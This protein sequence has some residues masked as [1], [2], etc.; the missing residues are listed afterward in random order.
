VSEL[1]AQAAA[2]LAERAAAGGPALREA[3]LAVSRAAQWEWLPYMGDR[4][5]TITVK[6]RFIASRTAEIPVRIYTPAGEGPFPALA[7]FHGGCWITGNIDVTDR[8]HRLLASITNCVVV[9]VNYQK[10]PEHPYP[11]PLEDCYASY[12]WT[13]EHA[14]E[15]GLDRARIGVAGDSAG[16]NLAAAVCLQA[17]E[18]G[19]RLPAVQLLIYPALDPRLDTDSAREFAEGYGLTTEDMRWSWGQYA[20]G[21]S[22]RPNPLVAP[23][24]AS[25][26][27]GL[28]PAIV[29]TAGFD[30]LRDEG[31]SYAEH[32]TDAGVETVAL[33]YEDSIHGFLWMAGRLEA[34]SRMLGDVRDGL[35]RLWPPV[36]Q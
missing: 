32:L 15:L 18:R 16:G 21:E 34:T 7:A 12:R 23:A 14:D 36:G 8:P 10:A 27:R 30:I 28:P 26:L 35:R 2:I 1:S 4:D 31:Q 20:P 29:V 13:A 19:E 24:Q 33:H 25:S 17:R 5:E 6:D 9:A 3:P 22:R 11:V